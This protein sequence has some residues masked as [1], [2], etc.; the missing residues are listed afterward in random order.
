VKKKMEVK[1]T[2][3]AM[4]GIGGGILAGIGYLVYRQIKPKTVRISETTPKESVIPIPI[5]GSIISQIMPKPPKIYEV[6]G[7]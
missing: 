5:I 7:L 1:G 3:I 6:T 4:I 2:D